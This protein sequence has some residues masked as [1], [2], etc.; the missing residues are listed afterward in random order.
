MKSLPILLQQAYL[1]GAT[2]LPY[3]LRV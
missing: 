3:E 1:E 2:Q